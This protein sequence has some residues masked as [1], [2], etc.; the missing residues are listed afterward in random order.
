MGLFSKRTDTG[1]HAPLYSLTAEKT[2][3]VVGLGNP[4]KKYDGTRHNI[5]FGCVDVFASH[6]DF[7][8]WQ[9][10]KSLKCLVSTSTIVNCRVIL[11]KPAT[12]MNNSGE[13][14]QAVQHFY[15]LTNEQTVV[16][17]DELDID[18]GS[19][20]SRVSGGTAGH[21][22]VKSLVEQCSEDFGR[23]RV[24]VGPKKPA[25]IDSADFVLQPFSKE[26]KKSL[27]ALTNEVS[28]I[29]SEYLASGHLPH[30]TRSFL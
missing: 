7:P 21:N 19:I 14:V 22:G 2:V 4:G 17:H 6:H 28:V 13:A 24:G 20:R 9:D 30:D 16:I 15:K 11:I 23:I 18:F 27:T 5:G 25:A 10:K 8:A 1:L 29:L 3:L 12:F 26:Q